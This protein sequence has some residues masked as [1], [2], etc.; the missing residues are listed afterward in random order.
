MVLCAV[1]LSQYLFL[2]LSK[3]SKGRLCSKKKALCPD[4]QSAES[5]SMRWRPPTVQRGASNSNS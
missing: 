5:R 1:S 4:L 3:G 2:L